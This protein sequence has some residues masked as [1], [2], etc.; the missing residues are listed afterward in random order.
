MNPGFDKFEMSKASEPYVDKSELIVLTNKIFR[1]ENRF[2]C[3]S[4]P[5]RFGKTMAANMLAAYYG[6][7]ACDLFTDLKIVNHPTYEKHLNQYNVIQINIQEFLSKTK[8]VNELL[9]SL[10]ASVMAELIEEY[11]DI[12][13]RNKNDFIQVMKDV[14]RA[15]SRPYVIL[16]DDIGIAL[17]SASEYYWTIRE[18]PTGKGFSDIVFIPH[19]KHVDKPALIVEL[20][21]DKS[22]TSAIDQIK[23]KNYPAAL[24]GY[25]GKLLLVGINC[26]KLS[27]T[28]KCAIE[29]WEMS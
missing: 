20:K 25:K 21:W 2:I 7:V 17:Y 11:P 10:K 14:Y 16:L 5:R 23:Q 18:L 13:F 24:A 8:S 28:H 3:I 9:E 27:K 15:T 4:R 1:T 22:A 19:K 26:D 29:Q 12:T 6:N